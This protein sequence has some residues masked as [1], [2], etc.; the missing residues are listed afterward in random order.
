MSNNTTQVPTSW[1]KRLAELAEQARQAQ[2]K[3]FSTNKLLMPLVIS[4]LIG[5]A[6]SVEE[7]I[8]IKEFKER[9]YES[10]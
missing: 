3:W 8:K 6:S 10:I 1:L 4:S 5:Y 7:L 9:E 2:D